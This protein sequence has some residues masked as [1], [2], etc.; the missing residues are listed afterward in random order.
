[1]PPLMASISEAVSSE[2]SGVFMVVRFFL[3]PERPR[4]GAYPTINIDDVK[5]FKKMHS[6]ERTGRK[7]ETVLYRA[8][9]TRW[10]D[11]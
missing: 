11:D 3:K 5:T 10:G 7:C 4:P 6:D 1:M 2:S 8:W 9:L